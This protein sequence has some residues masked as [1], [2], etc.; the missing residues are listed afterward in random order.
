MS[1]S[2]KILADLKEIEQRRRKL[3][4]ER[5]KH[6]KTLTSQRNTVIAGIIT[7]GGIAASWAT[8]G[9]S[10]GASLVGAGWFAKE[11]VEKIKIQKKLSVINDK[12]QSLNARGN[13]LQEELAQIA[14]GI[15]PPKP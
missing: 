6:I 5:Q 12:L 8:F 4:A 9:I 7:V 14:R 11:T 3:E 2:Q 15:P 10:L 1:S 13:A